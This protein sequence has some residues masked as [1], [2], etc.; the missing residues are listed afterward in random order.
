MAH[1]RCDNQQDVLLM[2]R[3]VLE[4]G[5][6]GNGLKKGRFFVIFPCLL[7]TEGA[8]DLHRTATAERMS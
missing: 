1:P 4:T 6:L 8:S 2:R 3:A 5:V 7:Q